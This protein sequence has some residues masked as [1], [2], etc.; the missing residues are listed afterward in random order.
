[1]Q[2]KSS[3]LLVLTVALSAAI[4][5]PA[6]ARAQQQGE[7]PARDA[8][9]ARKVFGDV[10]APRPV[11]VGDNGETRLLL[12][13]EVA[14]ARDDEAGQRMLRALKAAGADLDRHDPQGD[15]ALHVAVMFGAHGTLRTLLALG[16]AP[17]PR[18]GGGDTPLLIAAGKH[19]AEAIAMLLDHGADPRVVDA[20]GDTALTRLLVGAEPAIRYMH[21]PPDRVAEMVRRLLAAGADPDHPAK[22]GRTPLHLAVLLPSGAAG[23]V[24]EAL[25]NAGADPERKDEAGRTPLHLAIDMATGSGASIRAQE[26]ADVAVVRLLLDAAAPVDTRDAA[27]RPP[28]FAA[29]ERACAMGEKGSAIFSLLLDRGAD[30]TL[31]DKQGRGLLEIA[32]CPLVRRLI[33]RRASEGDK[34]PDPA[35]FARLAAEDQLAIFVRHMARQI[36]QAQRT[37]T[38][39]RPRAR[40]AADPATLRDAADAKRRAEILDRFRDEMLGL[41]TLTEN[42]LDVAWRMGQQIGLKADRQALKQALAPVL[43]GWQDKEIRDRQRAE[44]YWAEASRDYFR[45]LAEHDDAWQPSSGG[46]PQV[47]DKELGTKLAALRHDAEIFSRILPD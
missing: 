17:N 43:A 18:N 25:L 7:D 5:W 19:D 3:M 8:A 10:N 1:M 37:T 28:L 30:I 34:A 42:G 40:R 21:L 35:H 26:Q 39:L 47:A 13:V 44:Y 4:G 27:G 20:K 33:E 36:R 29:G 15:T 16:A 31:K 2:Q 32:G 46:P 24:A 9:I 12:P 41:I 23:P 22:D 6:A 11:E 14:A 38:G 45:L